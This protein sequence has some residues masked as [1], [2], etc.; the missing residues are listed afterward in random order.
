MY[1]KSSNKDMKQYLMRKAVMRKTENLIKRLTKAG[2]KVKLI[3]NYP[4]KVACET[5][6][7]CE[8]VQG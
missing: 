7:V 6:F 4:K 8:K 2:F 5:L 3:E 1:N